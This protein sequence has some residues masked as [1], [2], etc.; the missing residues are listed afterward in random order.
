MAT[1]VF[2]GAS[3][4]DRTMAWLKLLVEAALDLVFSL[5]HAAGIYRSIVRTV[6]LFL[7]YIY[8]L[9]NLHTSE[10]WLEVLARPFT[11]TDSSL[12]VINIFWLAA[13]TIIHPQ[14]IR[15]MLAL[16]APYILIHQLASVYLA[17]IFEKK[18][19]LPAALSTRRLLPK[20]T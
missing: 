2:V 16:V 6:G 12:F 13:D 4:Y 18:P 3:L 10:A 9:V 14:L 5:K 11:A 15:N 20:T 17:D 8:F 1:P 7:F 19:K